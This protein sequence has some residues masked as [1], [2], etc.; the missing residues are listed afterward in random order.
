MLLFSCQ[1]MSNSFVTPWTVARQAPLSM[2]FPRQ[3]DSSGLSLPSPGDL[4]EGWNPCLLFGR[5]I[6]YHCITGEGLR[7]GPYVAA[8]A[9][10]LQSCLTLCDP[11]DC[12][13]PGFSVHGILQARVM[14]R[15][16]MPSSR[17]SSR[18]RDQTRDSCV[19]CTGRRVLFH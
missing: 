10:S 7:L 15:V 17:G 6:L 4:P 11:M 14:E 2:G 3:E 1:L 13:P 19:S 16:A 5:W 8:A 12:S 18:P 9:K